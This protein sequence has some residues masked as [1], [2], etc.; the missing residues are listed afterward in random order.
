MDEKPKAMQDAVFPFLL[1]LLE[2][3]VL[4]FAARHNVD[5][6]VRRRNRPISSFPL[7]ILAPPNDHFKVVDLIPQ[8]PSANPEIVSQLVPALYKA[9]LALPNMAELL[10]PRLQEIIHCI[11]VPFLQQN[12]D[13]LRGVIA[14]LFEVGMLLPAEKS[15]SQ[16]LQRLFFNVSCGSPAGLV[17]Y[18]LLGCRLAAVGAADDGHGGR[19][20]LCPDSMVYRTA[21]FCDVNE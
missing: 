4:A 20:G 21:L 10:V 14:H 1:A 9:L 3:A 5:C 6:E 16:Q 7:L 11:Q 19:S 13:S 12:A 8:L 15:G 17:H 2:P 18:T